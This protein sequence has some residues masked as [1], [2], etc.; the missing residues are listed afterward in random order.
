MQWEIGSGQVKFKKLIKPTEA[1]Y[2]ILAAIQNIR[3]KLPINTTLHHVKGHQDT[4]LTMVLSREVWMNIEMDE[5]VKEKVKQYRVQK[6]LTRM[7]GK[8]WACSINDRKLV[9][10]IKKQLREHMH[11]VDITEYWRKN[12]EYKTNPR[13]LIGTQWAE[14]WK[15]AHQ[16]NI[17]GHAN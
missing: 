13:K 16:H 2:N 7:L 4:G 12:R 10:N 9:K 15:K 3:A 1:H 17:A 6:G 8:L 5:Q 14:R 11:K